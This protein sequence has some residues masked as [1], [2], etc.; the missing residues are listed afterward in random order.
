MAAKR[1]WDGVGVALVTM[2]DDT[3]AVDLRAS[4]DHAA[5][6]V[7]LGVA[8]VLVAGTTGEA[9]ALDDEERSA[10]IDAVRTAVPG[11]PVLAGAGAA[12]AMAALRRVRGALD[13]GAAA[14]L[15]PPPRVCG[16]LRAW[17]QPLAAAVGEQPLLGYHF[18]AVLGGPGL[19]AD[20]LDALPLDGVKD[21]SGDAERLLVELSTWPG[22][23]Y[24]G[25][26]ALVHAAGALRAAGAIL[27]AANMVPELCI[28]A[29]DGDADAQRRLIAAH[30]DARRD[31]PHGLKAATARRF[32]TPV[33]T[34]LG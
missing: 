34:R 31:F 8:G 5:A 20:A 4:A 2:F 12:H 13:A 11:V 18:P 19:P 15:V 32:G 28:A 24:T 16:D 30:L 22:A 9:D 10:L 6:L 29:W 27:A 17:Y 7:A 26:S 33:Q 23:V 1:L 25:S 3:G 14:V 21:S